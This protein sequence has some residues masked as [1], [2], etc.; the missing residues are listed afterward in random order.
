MI[1]RTA[2][3][4]P[5]QPR[6]C[7]RRHAYLVQYIIQ[8]VFSKHLKN[9]NKNPSTYNKR[10]VNN[11]KRNSLMELLTRK[12]TSCMTERV[13]TLMLASG[14]PYKR[15]LETSVAL[16]EK[17]T[18]NETRIMLSF[19]HN[20]V[21]SSEDDEDRQDAECIYCSRLFSKDKKGEKWTG[22]VIAS[23]RALRRNNQDRHEP[24][25]E[26]H[27]IMRWEVQTRNEQLTQAHA[28]PSIPSEEHR[29]RRLI[30]IEFRANFEPP[31][32]LLH[33]D[34]NL[35]HYE[36]LLNFVEHV[37]LFLQVNVFLR[38][39]FGEYLL[40]VHPENNKTQN[41]IR[42]QKVL[43]SF[44]NGGQSRKMSGERCEG[45]SRINWHSLVFGHLPSHQ[46]PDVPNNKSNS[47]QIR[48]YL[49]LKQH[50]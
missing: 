9:Q 30:E 24:V 5:F 26:R 23:Q 37:R 35:V 43:P 32:H 21:H 34:P 49:S 33:E 3:W 8:P 2:P 14:A 41:E 36:E 4:I 48:H 31:L 42:P 47:I 10:T 27:S 25:P 20:E 7:Q 28:S 16:K 6:Q 29:R 44:A 38:C 19:T 50:N 39:Q 46:L 18:N 11:E 1:H 12:G 40:N 17:T 45:G 15:Q 22:S 13:S